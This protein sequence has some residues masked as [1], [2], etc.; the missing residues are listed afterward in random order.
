MSKPI[1]PPGQPPQPFSWWETD[2]SKRPDIQYVSPAEAEV[3]ADIAWAQ[4]QFENGA[5][6]EYA[7]KYVGVVN[8]TV[9]AA[10]YDVGRVLDLAS[11]SA[12][13]PISRVALFHVNDG[14]DWI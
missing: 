2:P 4:S 8:R 3:L 10:D 14:R 7:G 13:V 1:V 9:H 6:A 5:F 12:G 11:Q